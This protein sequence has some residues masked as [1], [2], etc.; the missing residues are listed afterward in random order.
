MDK[1]QDDFCRLPL[2]STNLLVGSPG[3]GKTTSLIK[4]LVYK[5]DLTHLIETDEIELE[6]DKLKSWVM[7]TPNELLKIYLKEAMNKEGLLATDTQVIT[8]EKERDELGR[9]VLK[10]LKTNN[11]GRFSPMKKDEILLN[12]T[13]VGL[14]K[15]TK[16]FV[17]FFNLNILN[18]FLNAVKV[19]EENKPEPKII[20]KENFGIAQS[21]NKFANECKLL[22]LLKK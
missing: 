4:R 20:S 19:L 15:Y 12:N 8:W 16:E 11:S 22:D 14:I 2:K 9:D 21:F 3:T 6:N 1:F 13:S 5:S 10:F 18:S 7:F 17:D